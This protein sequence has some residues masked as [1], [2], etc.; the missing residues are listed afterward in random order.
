MRKR[1][2]RQAFDR[3]LERRGA[4]ADSTAFGKPN[5][6]LSV[7]SSGR[8]TTYVSAEMTEGQEQQ[9]R[10]EAVKSARAQ[11]KSL[12]QAA[13]LRLGNVKS[14]QR[15]PFID[16]AVSSSVV[17]AFQSSPYSALHNTPKNEREIVNVDPNALGSSTSSPSLRIPSR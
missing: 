15:L 11:A 9:A 1:H 8:P 2:R 16:H 17:Y 6:L 3:S 14:I 7:K 5:E 13:G 4:K 12:A 10:S